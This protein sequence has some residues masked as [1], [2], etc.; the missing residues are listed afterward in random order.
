MP[1]DL[2]TLETSPDLPPSIYATGDQL[3]D[4]KSRDA[5]VAEALSMGAQPPFTLNP[6][7]LP[8]PEWAS[9]LRLLRYN[10]IEGLSA[11]AEISQVLGG[12]YT[13]QATGR[14]GIA[15]RMPNVELSLARTNLTRSIYVSGYRHLVPAS[16]WGNPLSFGSS[17]SAV[18]F[19]RDE[20]FYY[21]A[22]GAELGGRTEQ[23]TP[24]EWRLFTEHERTAT[25]STRFSLGGNN[26]TPNIMATSALYSGA[27]LRIRH[28]HGIDP[29]GFR[30]FTDLRLEG[31]TTGD[32]TY[33]RGAM[34]LTFT[35]GIGSY[36]GALTLSGGSS[37]GAITS[38]RRWYLGGTHTI[39]GQ[40]PDTAQSGSAFWMARL[41][42]GRTI[43]GA[44]P[45][46]FSDI[47]WTGDRDR[48]RDIGRP[49]SGVGAGVSLLDGLMRFDVARGLFPRKQ[50][51]VDASVEAMW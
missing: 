22:T 51:R 13:T 47:G 50:W 20:G 1:C 36:A 30:V 37:V 9:G 46:V 21:R 40:S 10:R 29:N 39:R 15:D 41:E 12:G 5:L 33:G 14:F 44:R 7:S 19:G 16:D 42:A 25:L 31:A 4:I 38:Q 17:V 8:R 27:A 6:H 34:D 49:L 24:I 23:G 35:E 48:M 2:S 26:A 18:L 28:T 43:Q 45:V 3:F 32:S 11:G